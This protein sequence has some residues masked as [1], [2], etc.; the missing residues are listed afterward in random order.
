MY[1]VYILFGALWALSIIFVGLI[2]QHDI[3]EKK[4]KKPDEKIIYPIDGSFKII[5]KKK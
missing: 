1:S 3:N 5:W 2:I 4:E